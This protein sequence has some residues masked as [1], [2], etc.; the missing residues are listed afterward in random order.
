M[1]PTLPTSRNASRLYAE[2]I[3]RYAVGIG[4]PLTRGSCRQ[5]WSDADGAEKIHDAAEAARQS[6]MRDFELADALLNPLGQRMSCRW[7]ILGR[8]EH[9][10]DVTNQVSQGL[11]G[12][13]VEVAG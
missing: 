2:R 8:I 9:G 7:F 5:P 10:A 6:G 13:I 4:V 12:G 11:P 3:D 1:S